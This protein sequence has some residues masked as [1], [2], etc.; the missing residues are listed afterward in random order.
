[1]NYQCIDHRAMSCID[2]DRFDS[3]IHVRQKCSHSL[4]FLRHCRCNYVC[5]SACTQNNGP[6]KRYNRAQCRVNL[7]LGAE[8]DPDS[9]KHKG[10]NRR[11]GGEGSRGKRWGGRNINETGVKEK[12]WADVVVQMQ[13][14]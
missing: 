2:I 5:S 3:S 7:F 14:A 4:A 12:Y 1:M 13:N 9:A 10:R 11:E 8:S 6:D